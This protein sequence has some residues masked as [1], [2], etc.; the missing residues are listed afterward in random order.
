MFD[1]EDDVTLAES[2]GLNISWA[3]NQTLQFAE[4]IQVEETQTRTVSHLLPVALDSIEHLPPDRVQYWM[5]NGVSQRRDRERVTNTGLRYNLTVLSPHTLGRERSKTLG[6]RHSKQL[7]STLDY[8]ELCEVISGSAWFLFQV[9]DEASR[10]A[11]FCAMLQAKA[12]DKIVVPPNLYH[13]VINAGHDPLLFASVVPL[14]IKRVYQPLSELHGTAWLNIVEQGWIKNPHY[15]S[16]ADP[17]WWQPTNY[18]D[19]QLTTTQPLY[20]TLI[21]SPESLLWLLEPIS[22]PDIFPDIWDGIVKLGVTF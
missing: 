10:T 20:R 16:V 5:Y 2:A 17:L 9:L 6:H 21:Q 7:S 22:F 11:P 14:G 4:S 12:G 1:P 18:P 8:H 13:V 3:N 15:R 19:L